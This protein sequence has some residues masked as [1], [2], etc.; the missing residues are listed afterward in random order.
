MHKLN[1]DEYKKVVQNT[2]N[3]K[4]DGQYGMKC[5]N[6]PM[7]LIPYQTFRIFSNTSSRSME[8]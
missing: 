3:L 2:I 8:H 6:C 5:L 1:K 7:N 4:G